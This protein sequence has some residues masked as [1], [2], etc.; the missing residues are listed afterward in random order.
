MTFVVSRFLSIGLVLAALFSVAGIA[1]AQR[2]QDHRMDIVNQ[3]GRV[4]NNFYAT[5][6]GVKNWGRDLLGQAVIGPGQSHRFDFND[7]TGSCMFDFRAVLDNG[8]AIERYR[9]NV[10]ND[11]LWNVQ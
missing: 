7:G 5:N 10:C 3:T 9:V 1:H 11:T 2:Q 6:A 4:I 8:R